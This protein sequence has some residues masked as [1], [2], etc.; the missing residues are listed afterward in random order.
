VV[1][2]I[3][4]KGKIFLDATLKD[5]LRLVNMMMIMRRK[6]MIKENWNW[7]YDCIY[8][9]IE[10]YFGIENDDE[11]LRNCVEDIYIN[12]IDNEEEE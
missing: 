2:T 12:L 6:I 10:D 11:T 9:A 3:K 7:M 5:G 8:N 4:G 1:I